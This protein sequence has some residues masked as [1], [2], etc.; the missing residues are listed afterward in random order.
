MLLFVVYIIGCVLAFWGLSIYHGYE[1]ASTDYDTAVIAAVS[2]LYWPIISPFV[3]L[4]AMH[5]GMHK[6]GKFFNKG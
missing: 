3:M 4:Y 5:I 2:S 1:G 6:L